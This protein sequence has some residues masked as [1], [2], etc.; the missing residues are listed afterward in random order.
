MAHA[1]DDK[2]P[3]SNDS[4][5]LEVAV[6]DHPV[7]ALLAELANRVRSAQRE[8][9]DRASDPRGSSNDNGGGVV[10]TIEF[11]RQKCGSPFTGFPLSF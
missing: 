6:H 4:S 3:L 5:A 2:L 8:A 9:T 1:N 7:A 11:F 10:A